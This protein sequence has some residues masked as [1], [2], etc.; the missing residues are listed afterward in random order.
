MKRSIKCLSLIMALAMVLGLFAMLAV[1]A[2]DPITGAQTIYS[3][4]IMLNGEDTGVTLTQMILTSGSKY[5][6]SREGLLNVIDLNDA[7]G[8]TMKVLNG[9][10]YN[11][12]KATM[13]KSA[14]KYN[15]THD[16]STVIAAVNGDPW[17]VYHTD[18]DGDGK[19]ETG[20][21]VKHVSVSRGLQIIEGEVWATP[22]ISDENFLTK[23]DYYERGTP[24][25]QGP[26]FAV[27]SDGSY[28]I[29]KPNV[30]LK[31][32]NDSENIY[33]VVQG[34]NRLPAPNS[35]IIY[36]YRGGD[37]SM[38]YAD[39]YEMYV[40]TD[41]AAFTLT[42]KVTGKITKI[43]ESGDTSERPAITEN[44]VV[45][46][47]RGRAINNLQGKYAVGDQVSL[48]CTVSN[49]GMSAAQKAKWPMVTEAIGG[50]FT[51]IENGRY[52]G[53]QTNTTKYPCSIVGLREDG[54][55]LLISTT[56]SEDGSRASCTM[57]D[58][59]RLCE[60]LGLKTS[61]LFDGG[62]STTMV[63]LSGDYY[64]RRS[65]AVDGAN[66][67]RPV[68]N[69]LAVVYEGVDAAPGNMESYNTAFLPD[70]EGGYAP[71]DIAPEE[72]DPEDAVKH[73]TASYSYRYIAD[74]GNINGAEYTDLI[75]MRDPNYSSSWTTEEKLASIQPA[76]LTDSITAVDGKVVI[77]G[78]ALVN[79]GQG[80]LYWSLDGETWYPCTDVT[81]SD[82]S[83]EQA[84]TAGVTGNL[85][86]VS[87]TDAGFANTT[88]DISAQA[89]QTVTLR[90]AMAAAHDTSKL[91]HFLTIESVVVPE[92]ETETDAITELPT[93]PET[94]PETEP[95]AETEAETEAITEAE[96][97]AETEII[98]EAETEAATEGK[99]EVATEGKT[100]AETE[101]KTEASDTSAA[102]GA[103]TSA[104][105]TVG[106]DASENG[107]CAS[108]ALLS[109]FGIVLLAGSVLVLKKKE[110]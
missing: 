38:A 82:I 90:F 57:E 86:S 67:V 2:V 13:G 16:D 15:E 89:G 85:N 83:N 5:S 19:A 78:W 94:E 97:L 4:N 14:Q 33:T 27:L 8:V 96:T 55:P 84:Q 60:E 17:L 92:A 109:A 23:S 100:E 31:M 34:L 103:A 66:S 71:D 74:V 107:G 28:M 35:I 6:L 1:S 47:A 73:C 106:T 64:V 36:N 20:E 25:A 52:T 46:S 65:A 61:I 98:T 63:S 22:Q 3:E 30:T 69:G 104:G 80:D 70:P 9:G 26:V 75:G 53:Q 11:W 45:V 41:D 99:T 56:P 58:L 10:S 59:S 7:E 87:A 81:R 93:E 49:D 48:T 42:G 50:F 91:A 108:S 18:Y 51:L 21:S 29:G 95:S 77:S 88:A 54:T 12:S 76:V 44:I 68:L 101:S 40:E 43:F 39:A 102:T 110:D 79:G 62:G 24:A 37:V 105:T 32:T 72:P